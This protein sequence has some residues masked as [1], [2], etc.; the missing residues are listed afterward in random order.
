[1]SGDVADV[2]TAKTHHRSPQIKGA[3]VLQ[4]GRTESSSRFLAAI[5][6]WLTFM[7]AV[8]FGKNNDEKNHQIYITLMMKCRMTTISALS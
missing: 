3:L 7:A 1:M 4:H 6:R 5:G 2:E 8:H